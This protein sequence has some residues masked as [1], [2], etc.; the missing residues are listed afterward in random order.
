MA[1]LGNDKH[2]VLIQNAVTKYRF[3]IV[4][5]CDVRMFTDVNNINNTIIWS[6]AS[7]KLLSPFPIF[8]FSYMRLGGEGDTSF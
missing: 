3:L 2:V 6:L 5:Y 8:T 7:C 1:S 4:L